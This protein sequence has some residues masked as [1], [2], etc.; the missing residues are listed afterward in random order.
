MLLYLYP[1]LPSE[2]VKRI[3]CIIPDCTCKATMH[4]WPIKK[5]NGGIATVPLC[6]RHHDIMHS[7]DDEKRN[8]INEILM[9][10]APKVWER[11]K[12]MDTYAR[13]YN[14]WLVAKGDKESWVLELYDARDTYQKSGLRTSKSKR[15]RDS[16]LLPVR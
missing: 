15:K 6:Q 1:I 3:N 12:L 2:I 13:D 16:R 5:A 7:D 9:R 14:T 10:E 11:L 8:E 4:H